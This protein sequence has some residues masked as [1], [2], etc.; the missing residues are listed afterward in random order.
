[1]SN[2]YPRINK[3]KSRTRLQHLFQN[4]RWE[5]YGYLRLITCKI[6]PLNE[7]PQ[8]GVSVP[9]RNFKRA[10][11]RNRIKRLM[12]EAYRLNQKTFR[13][14]L[15]EPQHSM[16]IFQ[17]KKLP[18]NYAEVEKTFLLLCQKKEN[19]RTLYPPNTV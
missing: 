9:K 8:F 16:L 17:G 6:S 10:V 2:N 4:G 11:D 12:R 19:T 7:P 1:M 14:S 3:L 13:D 18:T 5:V 15:N